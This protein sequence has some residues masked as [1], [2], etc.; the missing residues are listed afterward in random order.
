MSNRGRGAESLGRLAG[1]VVLAGI[2]ALVGAA[3]R[4]AVRR[5]EEEIQRQPEEPI[6]LEPP[7]E[8]EDQRQ[9]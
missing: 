5:R 6:A 7:E 4:R 1:T 8:T 9:A 2:T 3:T